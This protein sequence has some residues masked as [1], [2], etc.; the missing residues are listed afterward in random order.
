MVILIM[1]LL[2]AGAIAFIRPYVDK[3]R[4]DSTKAKEL[5]IADALSD[6]ALKNGRLPCPAD[7]DMNVATEPFG[8]PRGS[9]ADGANIT[10]R[11]GGDVTSGQ[12]ANFVGIV[13]YRVL[14][15]TQEAARD[16]YGRFFTYVANPVIT[17]GDD[18]PGP[19]EVHAMCRQFAWL[20][21]TQTA[22]L[23]PQKARLC[24]PVYDL[25]GGAV[26]TNFITIDDGLSLFRGSQ[27]TITTDYAPDNILATT[28]NENNQIIGFVLISHGKN[29]LGAYTGNGAAQWPSSGP[30]QGK[31]EAE[32]FVHDNAGYYAGPISTANDD[33]TYFDDIL[34]WR[35]NSQIVSV[36]GNDT[37]G[38]P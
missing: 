38:H 15:L 1:G 28:Y 34:Y 14:G 8:A 11:C 36:F 5:V 20:N 30:W 4:I 3:V 17:G 31:I 32:N 25:E 27:S 2:L 10:A 6:F 22:N 13:P 21:E 16:G 18:S 35:T 29:G 26:R 23:N 12:L 24:C 37:C 9:G 19:N 33:E 7:S